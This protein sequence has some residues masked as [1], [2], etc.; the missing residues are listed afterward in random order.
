MD[1]LEEQL[2]MKQL[3]T[4]TFALTIISLS[5]HAENLSYMATSTQQPG[6]KALEKEIEKA[7]DAMILNEI[8]LEAMRRELADKL[9]AIEAAAGKENPDMTY[10]HYLGHH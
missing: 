9:T 2:A 3:V 5:A 6:I 1:N 7:E 10:D 4:F 8:R